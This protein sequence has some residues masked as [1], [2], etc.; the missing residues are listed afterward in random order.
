MFGPFYDHF[1]IML[2]S[3]WDHFGI[4]LRS[5]WDLFAI[6][7]RSVWDQ[8]GIILVI[9]PLKAFCFFS[10]KKKRRYKYSVGGDSEVFSV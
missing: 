10:A 6:I 4:I 7:L 3:F 1:G 2:G 9:L 8:F 5:R